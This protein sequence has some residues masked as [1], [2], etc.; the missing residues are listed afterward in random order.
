MDDGALRAVR[1]DDA[2]KGDATMTTTSQ[3]R[4]RARAGVGGVRAGR[5]VRARRRA[6]LHPAQLHALRRRRRFLAGPTERTRRLWDKVVDAHARGARS[7]ASST[8]TPTSSRPSPRTR[9]GYIDRDARGHRRPADRRA[10]QARAAAAGRHPHGRERAA[11]RTATSS[12]PRSSAPSA[13]AATARR[14]TT[15]SSTP[16]PPRCA[17]RAS[18]ASSPACPTPTAAAASSATTAAC[19]LYGVDRLLA[20]KKAQHDSLAE[21]EMIDETIRLAEE[22]AEQYRALEDLKAMAASYGFD[23]SEP[24]HDRAR[25]GAVAV[26]RLPRRGQGAER[27]GDEP[28]P[29]VDA[30]ST[31]TSSATCARARS[32]ESEAQE[33]V[34]QFVMKLRMVR[35]L[36]TPEYNELFSGDPTW[37]TE[38][39]G[40]MGED[41]RPLVTQDLVPLPAHAV[42]PR[43]RARAEPDRAVVA[44]AAASRSRSSARASRSRRAPIQ[45]ENDDLMRERLRRRLRHRLLRLGDA[46]RQADAVLRRARQPRQGAAVRHQR[47]PRRDLRRA[48]RARRR[49]PVTGE[50][51]DYDEVM[52]QYDAMLDWLAQHVRRR[53]QRHPL[54][55]R[56]VLLRAARDGAARPRRRSASWPA[57][58]R[59]CRWRPTRSRRSSTRRCSVVRDERGLVV[60]YEIEG[61]FPT[62]GNNDERVDSIARGLVRDFMERIREHDD[63]PRRDA[64]P[65]G[66]DDHVERGLRQADRLH[67]R[68]PQG[69]R[70]VRAGREPDARPRRLRARSPRCAR[71]RACRTSTRRTASPTRSRSCPASL[72]AQR[73]RARRRSWWACSTA[74][75]AR[76]GTTSTSTC[77]TARRCSTRSTIPRS[78]RC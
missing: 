7:G 24:A 22:L 55:A 51:L 78:T 37:V 45:Y 62:F 18:P 5:L 73:G 14:T 59:G 56:Q 43:P 30:S 25:G 67:A 48:G 57:A 9:P 70:A 19:A 31:S 50:V 75:S 63:V 74:T 32:T 23:I 76:A 54:H 35:Y 61:D 10:A 68:R 20:D 38:S 65:V 40:G 69:R 1:A 47:R 11:S 42:Q 29:H 3:E 34:D 44:D 66:A 26:L 36:R 58:S 64:H 8:P 71:W 49:E 46:H 2:K 21:R 33:I 17:R 28:R 72:G 52:A 4:M 16:T 6:R 15:A 77:W 12:R 13:C 60:D 53:A 41:G 27:R 39:I